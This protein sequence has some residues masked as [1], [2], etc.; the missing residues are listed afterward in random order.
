VT[1][2]VPESDDLSSNRR[3]YL[4]TS[5]LSRVVAQNRVRFAEADAG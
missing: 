2:I 3:C 4:E 1:E 5:D